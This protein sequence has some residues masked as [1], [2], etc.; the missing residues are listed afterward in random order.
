[1]LIRTSPY[2]RH[3]T[4]RMSSS[5][6]LFC[7]A[8]LCGPTMNGFRKKDPEIHVFRSERNIIALRTCETMPVYWWGFQDKR[9]INRTRHAPGSW[10]RTQ[11]SLAGLST[12]SVFRVNVIGCSVYTINILFII[13]PLL[14]VLHNYY[15]FNIY[16]DFCTCYVLYILN[17]HHIFISVK[18]RR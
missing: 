11:N 9:P 2:S 8:S 13:F 10:V 4:I 7:Y 5:P 3:F 1:M 6:E 16:I 14:Y 17:R 18:L 12:R 15:I